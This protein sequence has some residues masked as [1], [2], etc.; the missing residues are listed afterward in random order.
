MK[1][2]IIY[3]LAD[4][5]G[6]GDIS[7]LNKDS[8]IPTPR[9]DELAAKGMIFSDAHSCS[10]VCTPSRYGI[11]TGR[12]AWRTRLKRG[13]LG[14]FDKHLIEPERETVAT[15]LKKSGYDTACIGKWHLG[16]DYSTLDGKPA[17][18]DANNTDWNGEIKNGPLENGFDYFYG[19]PNSLGNTPYIWIENNNFIGSC[20]TTKGFTEP[21]PSDEAFN[22][23]EA[24]PTILDKSLEFIKKNRED[25]PY[26]L[27][28]PLTAPHFPLVATPPFQGKSPLG[29]YGDFCMQLDWTVGQ[30][31]DAVKEIGEQEN[32]L[33]I[34]TS[35]NGFAPYAN[36]ETLEA[37]GH[38]PSYIYRGYKAD[39]WEGGHRIPL[40]MSWPD[41]IKAGSKCDAMVNLNDLLAT[42]A[43]ITETPLKESSGEDSFNI[44][45]L[46]KHEGVEEPKREAMVFHSAEGSFSIRKGDWKLELCPGSGGWSSPTNLEAELCK[47]SNIQLYHLKDDIA[48]KVN[49]YAAHP[50]IV[51]EL[52]EILIGY[53]KNGRS[54]PG[55]P[56]KNDRDWWPELSGFM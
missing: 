27:Y 17:S 39:I 35:D 14:G 6:Y 23:Y 46:M 3:I 38:Y 13:V 47:L 15:L 28:M 1:P 54:T 11:L 40:I 36:V 22:P 31:M 48:E 37:L 51:E 10:S 55:V 29:D 30:I 50:N 41:Q 16:M 25:E 49:L 19:I 9:L 42:C 4:D 44:L 53:I 7:C 43:A 34:F 24:M 21:G 33:I 32:T 18:K 5:M 26:F 52:T 56:Q 12:Y 45:P 2:N 8:R 20:T